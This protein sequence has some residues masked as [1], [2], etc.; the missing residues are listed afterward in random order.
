VDQTRRRLLGGI[1]IVGAGVLIT[2]CRP[3]NTGGAAND[4]DKS[5]GPGNL[6]PQE[7]TATEDLMR[8]HG[9]LRRVL[10][11]YKESAVKLRQDITSVSLDTLEKAAQL[12]RAFGE[13]Y[14]E[15]KLEEPYIFSSLKKASNPAAVYVD[16]LNAQH[17]RGRDI[18]DYLL[19]LTAR[20]KIPEG[21][22]N[23]FI[24]ALESFVRMYEHHAAVEDTLVFPAWKKSISPDEFDE[25][26]ARFEEIE[27]QQFGEDG[28]EAA[29]SRMAEIEQ[30]LG[31]SDLG[32]FTALPPPAV[33]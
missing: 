20:D 13:E 4:N 10:L 19:K 7:V 6:E 28:F 22:A 11:V 27:E 23:D 8:E 18:T 15:R 1:P 2:A 3:V 5:G 16:V 29:L 12:F 14:H 17:A 26:G 9:I 32:Q 33:K 30:S 21:S 24:N 25:L 31:L